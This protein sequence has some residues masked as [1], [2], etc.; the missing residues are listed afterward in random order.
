METIHVT[1]EDL[2][3]MISELENAIEKF[4]KSFNALEE[5]MVSLTSKGFTGDAA[6]TLMVKFNGAVKPNLESVRAE[7]TRVL[8]YM[9]EQS[10]KFDRL[11]QQLQD[12]MNR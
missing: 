5:G 2:T 4:N 10:T 6:E 1:K 12:S 8:D 9:K 3:N 11:N 7:T